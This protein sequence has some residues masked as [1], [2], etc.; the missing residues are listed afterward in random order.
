MDKIT[1][2]HVFQTD[3]IEVKKALQD[4][5]YLIESSNNDQKEKYCVIYFSSN[6]IYHPN[7]KEIFEKTIIEKNHFEWYGTRI[8]KGYKHIF[9]RDIQKQWYLNG[10]NSELNSIEKVLSFLNKETLGYKVITLGSSSGGFAAVLFGSFLNAE[11]ILTFNGQFQLFDLLKSSNEAIDPIIFRN[12]NN[13]SINKYFSLK[14][15]IKNPSNI[16]YFLSN[17][18]QWD[19]LNKDHIFEVDINIISFNTSN[20]GIPFIKSAL[21]KIINFKNKKLNTFLNK[22]YNPLVFSFVH[23]GIYPTLRF[24]LKKFF[25]K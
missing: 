18:S 8:E 12:Q 4:S 24:L 15:I 17:K 23:G 3:S 7:S 22:N 13:P 16:Y 1:I 14:S 21:P 9:I 5:N 11:K 20:H 19:Q 6:N 25:N 2:P 10:I